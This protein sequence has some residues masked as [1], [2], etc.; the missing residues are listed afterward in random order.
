ML[1]ERAGDR[2]DL[3]DRARLVDV[4]H[5]AVALAVHRRGLGVPEEVEVEG[6][7]VGE[8]E[9]AAGARLADDDDAAL[10]IIT[11]GGGGEGV[12]AG[13]LHEAVDGE[14]D[15][16]AVDRRDLADADARDLAVLAVALGL[17]PAFLPGEQRQRAQLGHSLAGTVRVKGGHRGH[18]A[19]HGHQ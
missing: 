17:D 3:E 16:A 4:G 5:R 13:L 10:G 9:D 6:R 1:L 12:L 18:A 14:D 11:R 2:D 15:G 19:I 7:P 8:A